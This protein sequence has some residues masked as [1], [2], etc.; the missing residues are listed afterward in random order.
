ML[1]LLT[2]S[3]QLTESNRQGLL[4]T[5]GKKLEV[6]QIYVATVNSSHVFGEQRQTFRSH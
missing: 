5:P 2:A 3:E 4:A 1:F 6:H